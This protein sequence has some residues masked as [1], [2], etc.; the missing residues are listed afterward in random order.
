MLGRR[1]KLEVDRVQAEV[2]VNVAIELDHGIKVHRRALDELADGGLS[3]DTREQLVLQARQAALVC[4]TAYDNSD[5]L[6]KLPDGV[7]PFGAL[8]A[9]QRVAFGMVA[10]A[11]EPPD[12]EAALTAE[13]LDGA[14]FE[15]D[16]AEWLDWQ[17]GLV[18][19]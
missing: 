3:D 13:E 7:H 6:A 18:D 15:D 4:L 12:T 1:K 16:V 5:R 2:C 14:V 19:S 9:L 10:L 11:Q 17:L 8:R